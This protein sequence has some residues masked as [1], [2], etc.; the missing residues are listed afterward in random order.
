MLTKVVLKCF[1]LCALFGF[2]SNRL[3]AQV[4][5]GSIVGSVRDASGAAVPGAKV[6]A[7]NRATGQL[8]EAAANDSGNYNFVAVQPGEYEIKIAKEGFKS[9]VESN[10]MVTANSTVRVDMALA[11]GQVNESVT[12]EASA[13]VLQ[14][15]SAVVKS[16]VTNK[17]LINIPTPVGRNYQS[18]LVTIPGVAPPQNAHSVPTNPSRA[19][20]F[21]VNG[22][23][24]AGN[25]IR[26]D[27]ASSIQVWLPHIAAY[28]PS[29][30]AIETVNV[31]TN[32]FSAEQGLAGGAAIKRTDQ[33]RHQ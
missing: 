22:A 12:I 27:G 17:D 6:T 26:I 13:A 1:A 20:Q 15:D 21:N 16:E 32:S 9:G 28:V 33:E 31:V 24:A 25:N 18:L 7:T 14:T 3:D 2:A 19:L 5:Y 30:E 23:P 4:L 11:V 29:L 10:V 8:R